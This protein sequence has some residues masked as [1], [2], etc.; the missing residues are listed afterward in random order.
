[1]SK[2]D[3]KFFNE[4]PRRTQ[5]CPRCNGCGTVIDGYT[6]AFTERFDGAPSG[7][8]CA[9]VVGASGIFE[10]CREAVLLANRAGRHIAFDFN[11]RVVVVQP[12]DDGDRIAR[13]WWQE[14]YGE[15]PEESAARR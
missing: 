13:E 2:A 14:T 7:A 8:L 4:R 5:K 12:G 3:E 6:L 15:T 9:A 1:M 11:E 10:T